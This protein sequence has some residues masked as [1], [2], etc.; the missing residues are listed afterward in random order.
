[1]KEDKTC[2]DRTEE[3]NQQW[4]SLGKQFVDWHVEYG[5]NFSRTLNPTKTDEE[6]G[7][8]QPFFQSE[9]FDFY[10]NEGKR[11]SSFLEKIKNKF[12]R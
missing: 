11:F 4:E 9:I 1:M 5:K 3:I 2:N 10:S 6:L 8:D 7:L 12:G